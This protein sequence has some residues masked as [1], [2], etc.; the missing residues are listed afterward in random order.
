[1]RYLTD[2]E[3]RDCQKVANA[4]INMWFQKILE[5][6]TKGQSFEDALKSVMQEMQE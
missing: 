1:M 5:R 3:I 4:I 2:N 6:M